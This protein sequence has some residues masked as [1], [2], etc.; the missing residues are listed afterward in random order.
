M[1]AVK[2]IY[3]LSY[4]GLWPSVK[5]VDDIIDNLDKPMTEEILHKITEVGQYMEANFDELT[6]KDFRR[7]LLYF[8]V[9]ADMTKLELNELVAGADTD[10][11]F[12]MTPWQKNVTCPG[13]Q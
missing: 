13:Y 7:T 8:A 2:F 9:R 3:V 1:Q 12:L 11:I 6:R 4:N 10:S 5:N